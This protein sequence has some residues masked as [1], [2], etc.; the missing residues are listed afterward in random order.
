M[1]RS[2]LQ[3][4]VARPSGTTAGATTDT[5]SSKRLAEAGQRHACRSSRSGGT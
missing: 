3:V 5:G 1:S 2:P 4:T